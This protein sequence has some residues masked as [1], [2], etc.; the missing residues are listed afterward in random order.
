[1]SVKFIVDS[2]VG[3][4]ARWLRIMGYDALFFKDIDDDTLVRIALSQNRVVLTKDRQILKRRVVMSD[5]LKAILIT[6]DDPKMQL[7]SVI[8]QLDLNCHFKPFSLCLEC[9][10]KLIKQKKDQVHDRVPQHVFQTQD[11]YMECPVCRRVYWQGTHWDA[12]SKELERLT[13]RN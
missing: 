11:D 5:K 8:K 3:K 13:S 4:L 10:K 9:N 7:A 6:D 12:M 1:M 2:N